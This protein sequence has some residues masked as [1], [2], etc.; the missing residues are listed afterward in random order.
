MSIFTVCGQ[1]VMRNL[2]EPSDQTLMH[3]DL[4]AE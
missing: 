2:S 1:E 3:I 4:Y